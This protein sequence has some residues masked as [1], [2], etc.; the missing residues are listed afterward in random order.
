MKNGLKGKVDDVWGKRPTHV[1]CSA[2]WTEIA[3]VQ[4][5]ISRKVVTPGYSSIF[6]EI[7]CRW[8]FPHR[9]FGR[10]LSLACGFGDRERWLAKRGVFE[11]CLAVDLSSSAIAAAKVLAQED[12]IGNIIFVVADANK[13]RIEPNTYD[14]IY[15]GSAVH[16]VFDIEHLYSEVRGGLTDHGVFLMDEYVGPARFQFGRDQKRVIDNALDLLPLQLRRMQHC[17]RAPNDENT[18]GEN[19]DSTLK[20]TNTSRENR[21]N[22]LRR[23]AAKARDRKLLS[24]VIR[25]LGK[26]MEVRKLGGRYKLSVDFPG[27]NEMILADPTEAARSDEIVAIA[28]DSFSFVEVR[29][30]GGSLLQLL[31]G[32]IAFNFMTDDAV[33]HHF[34]EALFRLE[35]A[36]IEAGVLESDFAYIIA[37]N[38]PPDGQS[39]QPDRT[40]GIREV[41]TER[42]T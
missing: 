3:A 10:C 34:L 9:K 35:D 6:D 1:G 22:I 20:R 15:A 4:D 32:D 7:L 23:M 13:I 5:R 17:E 21:I 14:L 27:R 38:T 19:R 42:G 24:D 29:P 37:G 36:L 41:C 12:G 11:E 2:L 25:K 33:T 39:R 31:L 26:A 30:Y 28:E 18:T 8:D 16:H 40:L